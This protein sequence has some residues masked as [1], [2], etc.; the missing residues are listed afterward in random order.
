MIFDE[1]TSHTATSS[2]W[3]SA[4]PDSKAGYWS[5]SFFFIVRC[6]SSGAA[7]DSSAGSKS[8][9]ETLVDV[10]PAKTEYS[11]T[12]PVRIQ[13]QE[14][15]QLDPCR[16]SHEMDLVTGHSDTRIISCTRHQSNMRRAT[17]VFAALPS[18]DILDI[19]CSD[20]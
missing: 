16:Y 1:T 4:S 18:S 6:Y 5:H 9:G 10:V 7:E 11:E 15:P 20:I 12:Q 19:G 8:L 2:E 3:I 17:F 13:S 14:N